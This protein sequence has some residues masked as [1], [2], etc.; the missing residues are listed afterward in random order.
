MLAAQPPKR[1]LARLPLLQQLLLS[2]RWVFSD[3]EW[4][5][6]RR[7]EGDLAVGAVPLDDREGLAGGGGGG[8]GHCS[9]YIGCTR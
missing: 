6:G 4:R 7:A 3:R 1:R 2:A 9:I 8:G 5:P